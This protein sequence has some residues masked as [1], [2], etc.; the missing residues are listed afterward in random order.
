MNK[1]RL[2]IAAFAVIILSNLFVFAKVLYNRANIISAIELSERELSMSFNSSYGLL[3]KDL[4][5]NWDTLSPEGHYHSLSSNAST[6][7]QL[8][9]TGNCKRHEQSKRGFAILQLN[10]EAFKAHQ[11]L[12]L[13]RLQEQ[14]NQSYAAKLKDEWLNKK[15]RLYVIAVAKEAQQLQQLIRKPKQEF[16]VKAHF[17]ADCENK[18]IH[19]LEIHPSTLY[20]SKALY[21]FNKEPKHFTAQLHIGALGDAWIQN[22]TADN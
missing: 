7:K 8:G 4:R 11:A 16:I 3:K 19:I 21:D 10:G 13:Q 1:Q 22:I 9:F 12:N 5:L 18:L 15:T 20:L 14:K 2:L 17:S 6:I